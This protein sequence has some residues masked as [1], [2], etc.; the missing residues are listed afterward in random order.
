MLVMVV[1]VILVVL[2]VLVVLVKSTVDR[3][4]SMVNGA[5]A[6]AADPAAIGLPDLFT[7]LPADD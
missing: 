2:V 6:M 3:P 4:Q 7:A 1:K 5:V